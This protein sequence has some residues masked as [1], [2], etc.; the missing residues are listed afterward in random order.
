M[1][2]TGWIHLVIAQAQGQ[3]EAPP[4]GGILSMLP[5]LII[6]FLIFYFVLIRPEQKKQARARK[7]L[8]ELKEGDNIV[9][10]SGIHGTIKKL[11]DDVVTLQVADNVRIKIERSAIGKVKSTSPGGAG[12]K[13]DK[14]IEKD[15]DEKEKE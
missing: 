8:E 11:K 3:A 1:S 4:P 10:L 2:E 12:T 9:T 13:K 7:M 5:P 6:M 15:K 14:D